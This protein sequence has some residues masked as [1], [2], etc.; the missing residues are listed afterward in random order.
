MTFPLARVCA[1]LFFTGA[2]ALIYQVAWLRELRLIFGS[3]TAA[4]AA[5][6]SIFMGGLGAG[7]LVLGKRADTAKNP[8]R[9]YAH[10]ELLVAVTTAMTPATV[11]I[12][13]A[14][15]LGLG[16]A[17]KL[18][19]TGAM[20]VRLLLSVVVLS[21]PTFLMGGT[22][23]AAARAVGLETDAGRQR[24]AALYGVNTL[25]AVTGALCANFLLL[26]VFG[27]RFTLWLACLSNVLVGVLAR[28][29]SRSPIR[30]GARPSAT[31]AASP[32]Q[33]AGEGGGARER[34][35]PPLAAAASGGTFML[36]EL[37]WY[38][39]LGPILGGSSYTF[40]LILAV[41]L[42]GIGIGGAL[43]AR[44][45]IRPTLFAF[46][47]TCGVEAIVIAIPLALGD[48][49]AMFALLTRPLANAG[50]GMTVAV[51]ALIAAVV[52]LPA[53][54]VSGA[55]FPLVIGLYGSGTKRVGG[56]VGKAYFANTLGSIVGSLAGGFGLLPALSAPTCWRLAVVVLLA[57]AVLAFGIHANAS[58]ARPQIARAVVAAAL[59]LGVST[60]LLS[61]R[62]PTAVWRHS[63]I[64]A[65]RADKF[66]DRITVGGVEEFARRTRG[67]VEWE[68]EGVESSVALTHANGF[69]FVVNGKA[70]GHAVHDAATQVMG[71]LLGALLHPSP[72]RALVVGLGTGSTAGWLGAVPSVE[73]VDVI[74][75]EPAIL[76]VARECAV[77]NE[78]VLD[79][80]KVAV[81][82]GDAREVLRTTPGRYDV[83]FSEPSNPFR[84]GISSLYTVEFYQAAAQRLADDGLFIQWI[85]AYEVDAG[86]MATAVVTLKEVFEHVSIWQAAYGDFLLVAQRS[87]PTIDV[88]RIRQRIQEEPFATALPAAWLTASAEG[89]MVH[90]I[91][92]PAFADVLVEAGLGA[93]NRDDQNLL[94]FAFA[95][96]VGR[97]MDAGRSVAALA[98]RLRLDR[99]AIRGTLDPALLLEERWLRQLHGEE[100]LSPPIDAAP[101]AARPFGNVLE[102]FRS[103]VP[104]ALASWRRL[105]REPRSH[106]ELVLLALRAVQNSDPDALAFVDRVRSEAERELMRGIYLSQGD[107]SAQKAALASLERGFVLHRRD[108]WVTSWVDEVALD[109]SLDLTR[110]DRDAA[111]R[112]F[113]VLGE[114]F[115]ADVQRRPRELARAKLGR[116]LD[117]RSCVEA[118]AAM[119]PAPWDRT[120]LALRVSCFR[121]VGDVR[122][123]EAEADLARFLAQESATFG[124]ALP[125]PQP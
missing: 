71:G 14:A 45:R 68:V 26:E 102:E 55:Q 63:G 54:I 115:A 33:V 86:A 47:L 30:P 58:R 77:V 121:D 111:A 64:G 19:P 67:D 110:A 2:C 27:T 31:P 83:I 24:V 44:V 6:L 50:F 82:L 85:Q 41:A 80:A 79:N 114:R 56:D 103:G 92:S 51:W 88:D 75:I 4:S 94:E 21:P 125:T 43:Y 28:G 109:R 70:D 72:R 74:E 84:A 87:S 69:A 20:G 32:A 22:L 108:P 106:P 53:A 1:L 5:V 61:A 35:F 99:A 117:A 52:V 23:P 29:L 123:A 10:L 46:A 96:S 81:H 25:G 36:M 7:S 97:K 105:G 93:V 57:T 119:D 124:A 100:P 90:H 37:V 38:R 112:L 89:V 66:I 15:Y 12:A 49:L 118:L 48:R 18:G 17:A 62:G 3:S 39:M 40:G 91:A 122:T 104:T 107:A 42:A 78:N 16:G 59:M 60:V 120:A 73:Q 76:R 116:A 101:D 8:L 34:W 11:W 65:G 95:R 9:M 98:A 13:E 113:S